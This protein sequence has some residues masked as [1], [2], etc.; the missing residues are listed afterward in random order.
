MRILSAATAVLLFLI[1]PARAA[2]AE[3]TAFTPENVSAIMTANGATNVTREESDGTTFI[4]FELGGRPYSLSLR[5]CD[6]APGCVALLMA[7]GFKVDEKPNLETLNAF[8]VAIPLTT[9]VKIDDSTIA[10]G[11]FV[12]AI[13]GVTRGNIEANMGAVVA[14][15]ELFAMFL[16]SQV[17]ASTTLGGQAQM[18]P[19]S[20]GPVAEPTAV[21]LAPKDLERFVDDEALAKAKL[22]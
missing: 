8:N 6:K 2:D 7:I 13:G 11:R 18:I 22:R 15:P 10:F 12:L 3:F 4:N 5:L 21:R 1:G 9:I 16:K 17:V 20:G 19:T 14:S